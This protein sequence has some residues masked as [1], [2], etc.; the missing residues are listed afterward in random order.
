MN[1]SESDSG[2]NYRNNEN[3][4]CLLFNNL[5]EHQELVDFTNVC[6]ICASTAD[7]SCPVFDELGQCNDLAGKIN[8]YLP[9]K[10]SQEDGL[11]QVIC[12]QCRSTLLA[13]DELVQCC[14][15]ANVVLQQKLLD[16]DKTKQE[17]RA[18]FTESPIQTGTPSWFYNNVVREI[19]ADY[20][21]EL[22]IEEENADLEYVCQM[23]TECPASKSVEELTEHLN[24]FHRCQPQNKQSI[25]DF[26]KNNITFEEALITDKDDEDF[27]PVHNDIDSVNDTKDIKFQN[28]CCP[29]CE[30]VF[31]SPS[32][33]IYHLN[34]HIDIS[35][36][37][38]I[39]CCDQLYVNKFDFAAH[40]QVEHVSRILDENTCKSCGLTANNLEEL[41]THINEEH[42]E[43]NDLNERT[44]I[45]H[46]SNRQKYI[47]VVCP[48]CNKT[49]SNKYNLRLHIMHSHNQPTTFTCE[50]CNKS[51]KSR[52]SLN[53]HH[54]IYHEGNLRYLC[55]FCGEAFPT[56]GSRN[57]HARIH[58]G[59]KPFECYHC[60]KCYRAKNTLDRHMDMHLDIRKYA[61]NLCPNKFRKKTHLT[62]HLRTH[63]K[64]LNKRNNKD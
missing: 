12:E 18:G 5:Q 31:S 7:Q 53:Y 37:D 9:I 50:K 40:I 56:R 11:P 24:S 48:K 13:W 26:V 16:P 20:F 15:Q 60:G 52:G 33:L 47:P 14:I 59:A 29:L 62:Y 10:V 39:V 34:K 22:N 35:I 46:I 42:P 51:Y 41:Q 44:E 63:E 61:C 55:S 27:E 57:V 6:R 43:S 17:E 19:L 32:R 4:S 3:G 38:G 23:C 30:N 1:F 8:K 64:K 21:K 45:L 54:K 49:I 25:E 58:T 28:Y 36:T 2:Q